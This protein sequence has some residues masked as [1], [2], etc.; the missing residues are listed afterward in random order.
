MITRSDVLD[1]SVFGGERG[2]AE[3]LR[4]VLTVD[5]SDQICGAATHEPAQNGVVGY[6]QYSHLR[7]RYA[8]T[9]TPALAV[10]IVP[11][12]NAVD[13]SGSIRLTWQLGLDGGAKPAGHGHALAD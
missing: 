6:S 3:R 1:N 9:P 11:A 13:N 8:E 4:Q 10:R 5:P 7:S 12:V 2:A